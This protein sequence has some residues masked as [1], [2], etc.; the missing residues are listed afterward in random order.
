MLIG[1]IL[2]PN[3]VMVGSF[4]A[5]S[6]GLEN[7]NKVAHRSFQGDCLLVL[8]C[9]VAA[10]FGVFD[11]WLLPKKCKV[12]SGAFPVFFFCAGAVCKGRKYPWAPMLITLLF[13]P[14]GVG[15]VRKAFCGK[16]KRHKFYGAVA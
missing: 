13:M 5:M 4:S 11:W 7:Y 10:L 1:V 16:V 14:A 12:V 3:V 15:W 8:S 2:V 9:A 6:G